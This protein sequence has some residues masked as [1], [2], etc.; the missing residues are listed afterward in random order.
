MSSSSLHLLQIALVYVNTLMIQDVLADPAWMGRMAKE[1]FRALSPLIYNHG[2][3]Y[4]HDQ[5]NDATANKHLVGLSVFARQLEGEAGGVVGP[6][7]KLRTSHLVD[8]GLK[9]D[10]MAES[11]NRGRE[12]LDAGSSLR[13]SV[14]PCP[15]GSRPHYF[16]RQWWQT[17]IGE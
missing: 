4:R 5:V 14:P 16:Y 12:R 11:K 15:P 7:C 10:S 1:D 17:G 2:N 9:N 6:R 3:A 13:P 8:V